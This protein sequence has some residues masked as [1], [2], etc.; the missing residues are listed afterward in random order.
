MFLPEDYSHQNSVLLFETL[1]N[2]LMN[3]LPDCS[4]KAQSITSLSVM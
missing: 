3:S 4:E 1:D 2:S